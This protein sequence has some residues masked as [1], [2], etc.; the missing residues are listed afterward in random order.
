MR[1]RRSADQQSRIKYQATILSLTITFLPHVTT[2]SNV[3]VVCRSSRVV[4][5]I[6]WPA[7]RGSR[8]CCDRVSSKLKKAKNCTRTTEHGIRTVA[9]LFLCTFSYVDI[10]PRFV[11]RAIS[12]NAQMCFSKNQNG[13]SRDG[14]W[15][16]TA[17]MRLFFVF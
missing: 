8:M 5:R 6:A 14:T 10:C 16:T 12:T 11:E 2:V 15:H 3:N 1:F 13:N 9:R 17:Q 4:I 7:V